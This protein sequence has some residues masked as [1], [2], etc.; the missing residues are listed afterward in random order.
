MRIFIRG[1]Y[2]L[3]N[4]GDDLI[5]GA[6]IFFLENT[7]KFRGEIF[8]QPNEYNSFAKLG[9]R[10]ELPL[11]YGIDIES[12]LKE[13]NA[14]LKRLNF[15]KVFRI[16]ILVSYLVFLILDVAIFRIARRSISHREFISFYKNIDVIHYAGGGYITD[17]WK[18]RLLYEFLTLKVAKLI[19]PRIHVIGTGM[20]IGPFHSAVFLTIC[21]YFLSMF[22]YLFLREMQSYYLAKKLVPSISAECYGDDVLLLLPE[23]EKLAQ[24]VKKRDYLG[25]NLKDFPDHKYERVINQLETI[26]QQ[27]IEYGIVPHYF[28]FGEKPGPDDI[29]LLDSCSEIKRFIRYV[30][31]PYQEGFHQFMRN[32]AR[33]KV[34]IGFAYHFN[35]V[36]RL[37]KIPT[38]AIYQGKY[39]EQKIKGVL[40]DVMCWHLVKGVDEFTDRAEAIFRDV[41]NV[42]AELSNDIA[43]VKVKKAYNDMI[44]AYQRA[45]RAMVKTM[46][47]A[48][49]YPEEQIKQER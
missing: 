6:I 12:M 38:I 37:L 40:Q 36:L 16:F 28:C 13:K 34:G 4:F 11:R 30:H 1:A 9:L 8:L 22:D 33:V 25:V 44:S 3:Y 2:N 14:R 23:L 19:N 32:I 17:R 15:P 27:A 43:A 39:Y 5:L 18:R 41:L 49:K 7:I 21:K 24:Q 26:L 35:V 47:R 10:C 45:Y 29:S 31:S 48:T 20:G 46:G 42:N